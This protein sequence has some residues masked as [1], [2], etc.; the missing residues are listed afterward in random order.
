MDLHAAGAF[1]GFLHHG[2]SR[3]EI[4]EIQIFRFEDLLIR[5]YI[6]HLDDDQVD[7]VHGMIANSHRYLGN[8]AKGTYAIF[9]RADRDHIGDIAPERVLIRAIGLVRTMDRFAVHDGDAESG[10]I[11]C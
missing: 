5:L 9:S 1:W 4:T 2:G 7:R 10:G 11:P 6:L 3:S 8:A